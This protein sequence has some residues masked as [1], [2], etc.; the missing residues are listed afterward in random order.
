[1]DILQRRVKKESL[2]ELLN[3][4]EQ[5]TNDCLSVANSLNTAPVTL[6][7]LSKECEAITNVLR[8]LCELIPVTAEDV[9]QVC[10]ANNEFIFTVAMD[11]HDLK[12]TLRRLKGAGRD[13]G[14][15]LGEPQ[16]VI[17][18]NEPALKDMSSR[19]HTHQASLNTLLNTSTRLVQPDSNRTSR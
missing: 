4:C 5:V 12:A 7:G 11:V 6:V 17:V 14:I 15:D 13:S 10:A 3:T 1:M 9:Q 8:R 18:W 19:L 2:E 16:L